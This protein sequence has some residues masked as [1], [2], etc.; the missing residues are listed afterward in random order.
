MNKITCIFIKTLIEYLIFVALNQDIM[1]SLPYKYG[2]LD[3][4]GVLGWGK[5]PV[6]LIILAAFSKQI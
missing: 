2:K 1:V 5:E 6:R 3:L 4:G